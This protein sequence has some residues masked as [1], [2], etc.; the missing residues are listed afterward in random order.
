MTTSELLSEG[1]DSAR[2]RESAA[3]GSLTAKTG[4]RIVLFGAGR[5]GR[6]TAAA[7]RMA[8]ITPLA[9][10]DSDPGL[11]GKAIEGIRVASPLEAAKRWGAEAL[12]VVTTF[13]PDQGGVGARLA[14]LAALGCRHTA[15]FLP[16]AWKCEGILPHFGADLPSRLLGS[17]AELARVACLW[18]DEASRRT[19]EGEL[20]WRLRGQFDK[21]ADPAPDQYFPRD[22][23][24]PL[25]DESFIDG[26]AYDGDTLRKAPWPLGRVIA[27][28]PDPA[29]T[30]RLRSV[31][32]K[33]L[34]VHEV[35]LGRAPGV[36]CFNGTGTMESKRSRSGS[37]E[38]PVTTIDRLAAEA[39]PTFIK[40]DVEGDELE[41]LEGGR[42]TLQRAQPAVAVC[43][44]HRPED[45]WTIP[46]F[47]HETLPAHR[48]YLRAHAWDGFELVVY[49]I[50]EE[51]C[52]IPP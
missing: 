32:D 3:F 52:L 36:A 48:I 44:Y 39:R 33:K 21:G 45:L 18:D 23:L 31:A 22:I 40:L 12:F 19:F 35:L 7:L 1:V 2:R 15:S 6:K 16:L 38:V 34:E 50:P 9:F 11:Q 4:A 17:A 28:E 42:Q 26:G 51:R 46:L 41:A 29:S 8:G 14:E 49:A 20:K 24:R 47:L 25:A 30:A 10:A 37:L 5:L 43:L 13:R 27:I